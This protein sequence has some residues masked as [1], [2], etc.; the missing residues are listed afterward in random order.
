[1]FVRER[2]RDTE[3]NLTASQC[4]CTTNPPHCVHVLCVCGY[5]MQL[6]CLLLIHYKHMYI[7]AYDILLRGRGG[8]EMERER[9]RE[10]EGREGRIMP[11]EGL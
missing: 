2:E 4:C 6:L 8:R 5:I 9:E 7:R 11:F 10:R 1:M 3:R